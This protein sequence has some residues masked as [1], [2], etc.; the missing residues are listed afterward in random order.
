MSFPVD[1]APG[2]TLSKSYSKLF[3]RALTQ[4]RFNYSLCH[5]VCQVSHVSLFQVKGG[6]V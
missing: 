6:Q 1:I 5:R 3:L 2:T 4:S